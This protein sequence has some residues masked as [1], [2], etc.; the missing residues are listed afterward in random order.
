MVGRARDADYYQEATQRERAPG[1]PRF[2]A[3]DMTRRGAFAGISVAVAEGEILGIGGLPDSGK[4]AL[5]RA[6][7]G[8][9]PA[10]RGEVR[11]DGGAWVRPEVG[12]LIAAGL[13]YVPAERLVEGMIASQPIAWNIGITG[14]EPFV[15]CGARWRLR[16]ES[17]IADALLRRLRIKAL[18]PGIV[19]GELSGG[20]QQKVVL[21]RWVA[22]RPTVLV[23]DNPTRGIDAGAKEEIYA[24]VR[25]L[26][27]E[28]VAIVLIS[29]E[30]LE[31]IG[32][33]NRIAIMRRGAIVATL[34]APPEAKPSEQALVAAMLGGAGGVGEDRAA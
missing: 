17:E 24:L 28:G 25:A 4:A 6:L 19:C 13:G 21:A 23:L 10:D 5:G 1:P 27:A 18:H 32:L 26:T 31:L 14:G 30:L 3:R 33:S 20:N 34:A 8:I 9:E 2:A 29:D 22:R 11:F 12:A 7:A 15:A 16:R